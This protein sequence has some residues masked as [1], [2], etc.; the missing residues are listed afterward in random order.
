MLRSSVGFRDQKRRITWGADLPYMKT[1][2][3]TRLTPTMNHPEGYCPNNGMAPNTV[4]MTLSALAKFLRMLSAYFTTMPTMSPPNTCKA[5]TPH[6]KESKPWWNPFAEIALHQ[7]TT[8]LDW[9]FVRM[10]Q[11]LNLTREHDV[12]IHSTLYKWYKFWRPQSILKIII[13]ESHI[14]PPSF[15]G[16]PLGTWPYLCKLMT[17]VSFQ[18][19]TLFAILQKQICWYL[20]F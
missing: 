14:F 20:S 2:K 3:E 4:K 8:F 18:A 17:K 9:K 16:E 15:R 7:E 19:A 1:D 6:A 13:Y 5:T 11:S 10:M 12:I